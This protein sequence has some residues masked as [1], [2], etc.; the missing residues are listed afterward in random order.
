MNEKDTEELM[1]AFFCKNKFLVKTV[2]SNFTFPL[3]KAWNL[4]NFE[5]IEQFWRKKIGNDVNF[6]TKTETKI[7]LMAIFVL[8]LEN[9]SGNFRGSLWIQRSFTQ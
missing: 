8:G 6:K 9:Q 4:V 5:Q 3:S 2:G 1:I 7:S